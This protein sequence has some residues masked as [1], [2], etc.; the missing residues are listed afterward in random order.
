MNCKRMDGVNRCQESR[1]SLAR[2][3]TSELERAAVK[4]ANH[5]AASLPITL[6]ASS[7]HKPWSEVFTVS[8]KARAA[9]T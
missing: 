7:F 8:L 6:P 1:T 5:A 3:I 4:A 9:R 2:A